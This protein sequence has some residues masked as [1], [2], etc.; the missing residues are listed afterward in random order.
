MCKSLAEG[1][2]RCSDHSVLKKVDL[3]SL[4]PGAMSDDVPEVEW[5]TIPSAQDLYDTLDPDVAAATIEALQRISIHEPAITAEVFGA[6]PQDCRMDGLAFRLKSPASLA[7]KI[8]TKTEQRPDLTAHEVSAKLTD[9]VRYTVVAKEPERLVSCTTETMDE[10]RARGWVE[11]EAEQSYVDD[12]PYKG[13][14][15]IACHTPSGQ[16]VEI[17]FHTEQEIAIKNAQHVQ[18][19]VERDRNVPRAER[20]QAR[21][22]M[23]AA[24]REVE[25]PP[26]VVDLTIGNVVVVEKRYPDRYKRG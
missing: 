18:Y 4:R 21:E 14:H 9:F 8:A 15:V 23:V 2:D 3:A 1:G 25:R 10:L 17:Q 20:A 13:L 5:E 6:V 26:G 22:E 24:W 12:N 16:D 7:R 11:V 19:E